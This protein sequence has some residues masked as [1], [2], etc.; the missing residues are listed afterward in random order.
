MKKKTEWT[1][2]MI[3]KKLRIYFLSHGTKKYEILNR[4]IYDWESDY[5]CITKSGYAYECEVK[6]SRGDFFNDFHKAQKHLVLE[7]ETTDRQ[8]PNYFYYAC[9]GDLIKPEEVPGGYG[10]IYVYPWEI[11]I[12]KKAELIHK[13]K[14]DAGKLNLVDKFYYGMNHYMDKY[15]E[16][17]A[18]DY[19]KEIKQLEKTIKEYDDLLSEANC[20]L[21]L[22]KT[23]MVNWTSRLVEEYDQD[24]PES[25]QKVIDDH[26]WEML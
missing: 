19:K 18:R 10:L 6:I 14:V 24:V 3:Q 15:M 2:E 25:I 12:V 21:D 5:L 7:S 11:R 9:P 13:E 26:F 23:E 4:F 16:T 1:E 20:R 8:R 22:M 17:N